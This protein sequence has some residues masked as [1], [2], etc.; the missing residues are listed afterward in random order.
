MQGPFPPE[1]IPT[2]INRTII[3][4]CCFYGCET[5]SFKVTEQYRLRVRDYGVEKN[6]CAS[7]EAAEPGE[8]LHKLHNIC[9]SPHIIRAT[10]P[11]EDETS[12]V[13]VTY[14]REE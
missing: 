1:N 12:D 5:W 9:S 7:E 11:G 4:V 6:I 8:K 2:R 3:F 10:K 13:C 14:G